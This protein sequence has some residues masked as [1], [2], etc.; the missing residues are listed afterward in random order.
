LI[1][2][3]GGKIQLGLGKRELLASHGFLEP[4]GSKPLG[5]LGLEVE[6]IA[7]NEGFQS[8]MESRA[9]RHRESLKSVSERR[10]E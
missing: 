4:L 5:R 10:V 8:K 7:E 9:W 2:K 6:K 3:Q 1:E